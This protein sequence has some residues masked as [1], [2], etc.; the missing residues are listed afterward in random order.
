MSGSEYIPA[1]LAALIF[2]ALFSGI[3]IAFLTA[4]KLRIEL[5]SK[6]GSL[7]GRILSR[8]IK[9]PS[10]FF[11]TTLVGNNVAV[12][13]FSIYMSGLIL[14]ELSAHHLILPTQTNLLLLLQTV[15]SSVILLVFGEFLP[16]ALFSRSP[17][18]LLNIF[19]FPFVL[20]YW[21]LWPLVML[22]VFMASNILKYVLKTDITDTEPEYTRNDLFH[23]V[24]ESTTNDE[25][26]SAEVDKEIFKNAIEFPSLKVRECMIPRTE[27]IAA[28]VTES[29]EDV[30][31]LFIDSGH[32]KIP[33]YRES[34][35][36]II[37]YIH[38]VD[39]YRDPKTIDKMV[40]PII[41][42]TESMPA[43]ELMRQLIEK[44]R[45]IAVVVDEFGGTSGMITIEDIIEQIIGEI[46]DEHDVDDSTEKKINDYEYLLS[47]RLDI[48]YLNEKY[49]LGLPEGDYDTLGG[50]IY[51]VHQNIPEVGH[52]IMWEDFQFTIMKMDQTRIDEVELR[53]V[54]NHD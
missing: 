46:E 35:D 44:R 14:S 28:E 12:V 47:A 8:F 26:K 18:V 51:Y 53:I 50:L 54:N 10:H 36:N 29:I 6:K 27:I 19:S 33:V 21:L 17:N 52:V 5:N 1:I 24:S 45:S 30:K 22:I 7:S 15:I 23:Y 42:T 20:F 38:L 32:S 37:G 43:S 13:F 4:N 39:L 34:I 16:K 2:S 31:K 9:K 49:G 40:M 25:E 48:D 11:T 3:E 41:I